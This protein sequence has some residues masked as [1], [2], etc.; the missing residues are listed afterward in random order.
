MIFAPMT[1]ILF[2][3]PP[4]AQASID[5]LGESATY[6]VG[7]V[8]C[9]VAKGIG[10]AQGATKA[11]VAALASVPVA[12]I[13]QI[14][15]SGENEAAVQEVCAA[16]WGKKIWE[17]IKTAILAAADIA[18][19]QLLTDM[20]NK[21]ISCINSYDKSNGKCTSGAG[22]KGFVANWNSM[23]NKAAQVAGA[24]FL[25]NLTGV[26]LCSITPSIKLKIALL[27]VPEFATQAEC[28]LD[29]IVGN[30]QDF[31]NDFRT[32]GW[33]AWKES[34]KPNNNAFGAWLLALDNKMG[35]EF[36]AIQKAG[37][38]TTNGFKAITRCGSPAN[39][40]PDSP[41]CK[42][43]I[44][45]SPSG[46][47]ETSV[48]FAALS[49]IRKLE[50]TIN[51]LYAH[52]NFGVFG[53]YLSAITNALLNKVTSEGLAGILGSASMDDITGENPYQSIINTT[54]TNAGKQ[55]KTQQDKEQVGLITSTLN[56]MKIFIESVAKPFYE[57]LIGP[58]QP[59]TDPLDSD[60][61]VD[62]DP[63]DGILEKIKDKQIS[64]IND[65]WA[66][67][68]GWTYSP[69]LPTSTDAVLVYVDERITSIKDR[70]GKISTAVYPPTAD[71]WC[72]GYNF[73][74]N[75]NDC[76]LHPTLRSS[77]FTLPEFFGS[78]REMTEEASGGGAWDDYI[79]GLTPGTPNDKVNKIMQ[80]LQKVTNRAYGIIITDFADPTKRT[81]S[82]DYVDRASDTAK[83]AEELI[84]AADELLD[85][86]QDVVD[87]E[88]RG[89]TDPSPTI[90]P[91]H[92]K[93]LAQ[94]WFNLTQTII[95][96][97]VMI[98]SWAKAI[99]IA[100]KELAGEETEGSVVP[101]GHQEINYLPGGA[102]TT[103]TDPA[104]GET[105]TTTSFYIF[106]GNIGYT[107]LKEVKKTTTG[108]V[109]TK[110]YSLLG[111][112]LYAIES[113]DNFIQIYTNKYSDF[114]RAI[115]KIDP[116][117]VAMPA[118]S[119]KLIEMEVALEV[120][121]IRQNDFSL[122][123]TAT[124]ASVIENLKAA[125]DAEFAKVTTAETSLNTAINT[126]L[127]SLKD[128]TFPASTATTLSTISNDL[129]GYFN[130]DIK[131]DVNNDINNNILGD[132]QTWLV[133][134]ESIYGT[135]TSTIP[136]P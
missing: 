71:G 121:N 102:P 22:S 35:E 66:K 104:T 127:T 2:F 36:A 106:Q 117:L 45:T 135:G 74:D 39:E 44:V 32:G 54:S 8:I 72:A 31:Y 11:G 40:K 80:S 73:Y 65:L 34:L 67:G 100:S 87:W 58:Q 109:T 84:T 26:N 115:S 14:E 134:L 81:V 63:H 88:Y 12:D 17:G 56:N 89:V 83:A 51:A 37:K 30:I 114:N 120:W 10:A 28:T 16:G 111:T 93:T 41:N 91:G 118:I 33:V 113:P 46:T 52:P 96:R 59:A 126:A 133:D 50:G 6:G 7:R 4:T 92:L 55:S 19:N 77:K 128:I 132:Y 124:D 25:N 49:P 98:K 23:I 47:V 129:T 27:P 48:N 82:S 108:G 18:L 21:I 75:Y 123:E 95:T 61:I 53:V 43:T 78:L 57:K 136:T 60:G 122:I 3:T 125:R 70:V 69:P 131:G 15:I 5:S 85:I 99:E 90:A 97:V 64:I 13:P 119:N 76:Y 116:S 101:T 103:V 62:V 20:T 112:P 1:N 107:E 110:T 24:R 86:L 29:D 105:I 130:K 79:K 38:E 9:T 68:I 42:F 94:E